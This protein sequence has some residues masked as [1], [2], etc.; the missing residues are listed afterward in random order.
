MSKLVVITMLRGEFIAPAWR[1]EGTV[2][3][4][5]QRIADR[6]IEHG[7]AK[8]GGELKN[9]S[10]K[11]KLTD[12]P[13]LG[14]FASFPASKKFAEAGFTSVEAVQA[15]VAEKGDE[16]PKSVKGITKGETGK[17]SEALEALAKPAETTEGESTP[18]A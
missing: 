2:L 5:D 14:D 17:V 6:W 12:G 13:E 7:S 1:E 11:A 3:E 4:V 9:A 15:L 18:E 10:S 16:W 8:L